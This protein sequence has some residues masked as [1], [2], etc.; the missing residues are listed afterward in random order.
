MVIFHRSYYGSILTLFW[1]YSG[2]PI[3]S[4][5]SAVSREGPRD[6]FP[7]LHH[8]ATVA[9]VGRTILLVQIALFHCFPSKW[10]GAAWGFSRQR[11]D[12]FL[13]VCNSPPPPKSVHVDFKM[14]APGIRLQE[15][16]R[17]C[18]EQDA[19]SFALQRRFFRGSAD[20]SNPRKPHLTT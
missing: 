10:S 11:N 3:S 9:V 2:S 19:R 5:T 12:R 16:I 15:R 4:L 8:R 20:T 18:D 13:T 17:T 14:D 1:L 7:E 6:N